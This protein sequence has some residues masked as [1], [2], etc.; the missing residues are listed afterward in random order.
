MDK[1]TGVDLGDAGSGS[2]MSRLICLPESRR[3]NTHLMHKSP[4][5]RS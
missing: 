1:S 3:I 4:A 2:S 5:S